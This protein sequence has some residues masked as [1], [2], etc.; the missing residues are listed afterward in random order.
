M[1]VLTRLFSEG[2]RIFFLSAC[3]FAV[4][5]MVV[6]EGWL[7]IHALGGMAELPAAIPPHYWHAHEMIFGYA[8][9]A[10][11]GFFLTAV[12]NWTG[13]KPAPHRFIA[14]AFALWLAGRLALWASGALPPALVALV[15]LSFLPVLAGKIGM[16]L[17]VR[18]KPQ[19]LIFLGV[20]ALLWAAN[21]SCHLEWMGFLGNGA[22][23]GLHAGLLGLAA[24][25]MILGGRVT[26]GFTR[27]AMVQ[28]GRT[29]RLPRTPTAV[30]P[31]AIAPAMALP[32]AL[33]IGLPE[34]VLAP[35]A[36]LAGLAGLARVALWR[37]GWTLRRPILW[38]LHLS[39]ALNAA[40]LVLLGLAWLGFGSEIA[41]LHLIGIGGVGGMT[42]AMLSRATLGHAGR[43][44]HAPGPLALAYGLIPLAALARFAAS[45]LPAQY[46]TLNLVAGALWLVAFTLVLAVLVPV[47]VTP[48]P[49]RAPV[50]RPPQP[51]AKE[52][53]P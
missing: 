3:V 47:F 4:L 33:L 31:A 40:G 27:N 37:G 8:G 26:P 30:A 19:Q 29:D 7:A 14:L 13:A 36:L 10:L 16:Q 28:S 38:T 52:G 41:A 25:I 22:A 23:P 53:P 5:A 32:A 50:G 35:L 24:L 17:L 6:W 2:F 42:L 15:D 46:T 21:L 1:T 43:P 45:T 44:L 48:R 9:A 39:Y 11:A 12:P 34:P 49:P 18:P 20:L 51:A